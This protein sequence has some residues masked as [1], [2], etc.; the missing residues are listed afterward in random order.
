MAPPTQQKQ[1]ACGI[2]TLNHIA[3]IIRKSKSAT[4]YLFPRGRAL[5]KIALYFCWRI[6][7]TVMVILVIRVM[8]SYFLFK[9]IK[10]K[11]LFDFICGIHSVN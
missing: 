7:R 4:F 5:R 8:V 11:I 6:A 2:E 10:D 1:K 3:P 9:D